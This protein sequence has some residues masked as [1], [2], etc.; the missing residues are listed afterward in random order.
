[1]S[2]LANTA[3]DLRCAALLA[4]LCAVAPAAAHAHE[5]G[6]GPVVTHADTARELGGRDAARRL[7]AGLGEQRDSAARAASASG[8]AWC[9][10]PLPADDLANAV[11][12]G[13]PAIKVVYAFPAD[14]PDRLR[15]LA[16]A[17]QESALSV[18][19]FVAS[20][21]GGTKTIRF[22]TGTSCGAD[23]LDVA[24]V[25]LPG[26]RAAY[27]DRRGNPLFARVKAEIDRR[28]SGSP[29]ARNH[30]VF[31]DNLIRGATFGQAELLREADR[32]GSDNP[33]NGG[34]RAAIVWGQDG[35]DAERGKDY[36][37][38]LLMLHEVTHT[39]GAVQLSAP[40]STGGGHCEDGA[41]VMCYSESNP[42]DRRITAC[43]DTGEVLVRL[44]CN[45][46]D[47]FNPSPPAGSYLASHWNVYDSVF[48][49]PCSELAAFC[50]GA[51]P[52]QPGE[53]P[54]AAS[55]GRMRTAPLRRLRR[56]RPVGR[57]LGR[58]T[59]RAEGRRVTLS[60]TRLRLGRGH[61][62]LRS[63]VKHGRCRTRTVRLRA[64]GRMKAPSVA[65]TAPAGAQSAS[66][67]VDIRPAG[68]VARASR[69]LRIGPG[70]PLA[71]ALG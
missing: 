38:P 63:C 49:G 69:S 23:Y 15:L 13:L 66:G 4:A 56:G 29:G 44:D 55:A 40:H 50:G 59:V 10:S 57:S 28:L 19:R 43:P 8:S 41:D 65:A 54:G 61:W 68:A 32:P 17:L 35:F 1:V 34:G 52:A 30:L 7:V 3:K 51:A 67:T 24:W 36:T 39:L 27:L 12:P 25:P 31:V 53:T 42:G 16:G 21:S 6:P 33:N 62:R 26:P 45:K 46:D 20:E 14:R 18:A 2:R 47:Y 58:M 64:G 70:R 37:L 22:D 9:G 11:R 5:T 48:L 60:T 71:V